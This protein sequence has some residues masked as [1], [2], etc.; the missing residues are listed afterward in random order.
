MTVNEIMSALAHKLGELFPDRAVY[1]T[2]IPRDA[3]GNHYIRCIDQ[4]H[5]KKLGRRRERTYSFEIL[6]FCK[7]KDALVFNDWA[8]TMYWGFE[9]LMVNGQLVH[10]TGAH[11]EPGDDGVFHFVFDITVSGLLDPPAGEPMAELEIR[12]GLKE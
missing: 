5:T 8:E 11:A 9:S 10:L 7:E 3:D 2:Q 12:E 1:Y 6:Y 4:S